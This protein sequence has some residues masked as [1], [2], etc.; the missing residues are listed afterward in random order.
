MKLSKQCQKTNTAGV[1]HSLT[2]A[3]MLGDIPCKK[4]G[5]RDPPLQFSLRG[6]FYVL[7]ARQR[8]ISAPLQL[9]EKVAKKSRLSLRGPIPPTFLRN[10]LFERTKKSSF[11]YL[12]PAGYFCLDTK[13]T[14]K[15]RPVRNL[16]G[17]TRKSRKKIFFCGI[18]SSSLFGKFP[19]GRF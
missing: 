16:P 9:D 6:T 17:Q 5:Y 1:Q 12:P 13:V 2:P 4:G 10:R 15:S 11:F 14:K 19:N 3:F 18:S 8:R 7:F